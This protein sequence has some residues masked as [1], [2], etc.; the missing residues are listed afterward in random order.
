VLGWDEDLPSGGYGPQSWG[1]E[2]GNSEAFA[3][4]QVE[5]VFK[6]VCYRPDNSNED[7]AAIAAIAQDFR[8]T[9][10][11]MKKVFAQVAEYCTEGDAAP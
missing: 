6:Q 8:T 3:T 2:L 10:Y 4:C 11:S 1:A 7:R 9:G 5:K